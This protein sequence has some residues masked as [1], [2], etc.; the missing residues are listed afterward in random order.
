MKE[1]KKTNEQ[2]ITERKKT[3]KMRQK[4]KENIPNKKCLNFFFVIFHFFYH[5]HL[6]LHYTQNNERLSINYNK[7]H[8][9]PS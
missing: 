4:D 8:N 1:R 9:K 5:P 6:L 2:R 7:N 3:E